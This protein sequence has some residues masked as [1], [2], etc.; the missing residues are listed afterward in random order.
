ML[1]SPA[2]RDYTPLN[3]LWIRFKQQTQEIGI[4][5]ALRAR[6][7]DILGLVLGKAGA[8]I[9][10]GL[11]AG[12]VSA[13]CVARLMSSVLISVNSIDTLTYGVVAGT[14]GIAALAASYVPARRAMRIELTSALRYE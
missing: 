5:M 6:G 14:L 11:G 2:K 13:A 7:L 10:C 1:R 8:I 12:L 9:G 4:R 3:R